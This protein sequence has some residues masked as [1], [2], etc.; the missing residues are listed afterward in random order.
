VPSTV[1]S[2]SIT[3]EDVRLVPDGHVWRGL[4]KGGKIPKSRKKKD[5]ESGVTDDSMES[6]GPGRRQVEKFFIE[7][8]Y[9]G[10]SL[11]FC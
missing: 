10:V 3:E 8:E 11:S 2:P 5:R 4:W 1:Q 7:P 9:H 6:D